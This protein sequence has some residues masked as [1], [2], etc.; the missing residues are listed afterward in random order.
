MELEE[1]RQRLLLRS[2]SADIP[3][4]AHP[5]QIG[6]AALSQAAGKLQWETCGSRQP[7]LRRGSMKNVEG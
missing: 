1:L 2:K 7:R 5:V 4:I 6:E 3:P